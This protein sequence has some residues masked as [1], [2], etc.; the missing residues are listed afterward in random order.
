MNTNNTHHRNR[1]I[2]ILRCFFLFIWCVFGIQRVSEGMEQ[3]NLIRD[4]SAREYESVNE[5]EKL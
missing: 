3:L 1:I 2:I 4:G 5:W